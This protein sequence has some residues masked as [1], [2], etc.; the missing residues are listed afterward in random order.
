MMAHGGADRG[1]SHG[2]GM[3]TDSREATN[4]GGAGGVGA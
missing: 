1:R 2:G 3:A 4:N